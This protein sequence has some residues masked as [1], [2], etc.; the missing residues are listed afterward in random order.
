M[1]PQQDII[2]KLLKKSIANW[3]DITFVYLTISYITNKC[4]TARRYMI[5]ISQVSG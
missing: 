2:V 3:L 1:Q 4:M 5:G